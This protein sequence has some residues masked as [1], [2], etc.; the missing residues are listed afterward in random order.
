MAEPNVEVSKVTETPPQKGGKTSISGKLIFLAGLALFV[1]A[2]CIA[3]FFFLPS[4]AETAALAGQNS[5]TTSVEETAETGKTTVRDEKLSTEV[6]VDLGQFT[7]TAYQPISDTT[8]RID[9]HLFGTVG[10]EDQEV[11]LA[12]WQENEHRLR[13]QVIVTLRSAEQEDLTDAGLGLIKRQI[14]EKTNRTLGRPLLRS[15]I[16]SEFSF[17]EQ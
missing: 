9:L 11:F 16:F 5:Q 12:A 4:A 3:A 15:A 2:E 8:I 14:L 17:I 1:V 13:D 10:R 6:E 7:V